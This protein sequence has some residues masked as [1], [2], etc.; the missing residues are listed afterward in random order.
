MISFSVFEIDIETRELRRRGIKVRL[1]EQAFS[2]LTTLIETPGSVVSRE[3]IQQKLWAKDTFVDFDI[4]INKAVSHLRAALADRANNPQFIET[5][6][7]Q[8][9]RFLGTVNYKSPPGHPHNQHEP[10]VRSTIA[11]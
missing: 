8:G 11:P 4:G 6:P 7:R 2:L 9:Y 10:S 1:S 3:V 5:V